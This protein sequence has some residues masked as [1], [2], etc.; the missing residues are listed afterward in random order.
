MDYTCQ[1]LLHWSGCALFVR[2]E[3]IKVPENLDRTPLA[4]ELTEEDAGIVLEDIVAERLLFPVPKADSFVSRATE[5]DD[6][7]EDDEAASRSQR[8][9]RVNAKTRAHDSP[10][11]RYNL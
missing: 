11:Q 7:A 4:R 2:P 9:G 3:T 5:V 1:H 10:S 8:A 6:K